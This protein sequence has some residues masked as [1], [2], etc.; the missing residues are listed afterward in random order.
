MRPKILA[1]QPCRLRG[2]FISGGVI[3]VSKVELSK[4][5]DEILIKAGD[6]VRN[7]DKLITRKPRRT[8]EEHGGEKHGRSSATD[9]A[10]SGQ[11]IGWHRSSDK[12]K[13]GGKINLRAV[14]EVLAEYG[15]DLTE[16]VAK[17]LKSGQLDA[18]MQA[19]VALKLM[20]YV[21]PKLKSVDIKADVKATHEYVGEDQKQ[22]IAE[23]I[24]RASGGLT[25]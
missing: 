18:G 23:E 16:E 12:S 9:L 11:Q 25:G 20:E 6:N 17:V 7:G 22:R 14:E 15:L 1:S 8:V 3:V 21:R 2:F 10:N 24:L 5:A 13:K 19:T 4:A